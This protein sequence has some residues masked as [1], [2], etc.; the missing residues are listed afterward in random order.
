MSEEQ[1]RSKFLKEVEGIVNNNRNAQYG[2]A[3]DSFL[4][5]ASLWTA[6][7]QTAM[8]LGKPLR[9]SPLDVALMMD[10]MKTARLAA[11]PTHYDS[12]IDKAGYSACGGGIVGDR[13]RQP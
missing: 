12:W 1:M 6:Y 4:C 5:I 8:H 3:E 11:N 9:I 13:L 2:G 7:L 10:L